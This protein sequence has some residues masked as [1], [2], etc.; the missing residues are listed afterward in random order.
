MSKQQELLSTAF[1]SWRGPLE[2][3]DDVLVIGIRV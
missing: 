2:Q 3:V 1:E